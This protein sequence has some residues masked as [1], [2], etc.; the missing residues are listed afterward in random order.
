MQMPDTASKI[1]ICVA[2]KL[3][4]SESLV[5]DEKSFATDL[6]MDS[7]DY[8]EMIVD[9]EKEFNIKIPEEKLEKLTTVKSLVDFVDEHTANVV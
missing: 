4:V 9:L 1:R 3:G 6:A 2:D 5:T 7:L 8:Y